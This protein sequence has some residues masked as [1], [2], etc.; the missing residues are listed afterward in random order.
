MKTK[1][2]VESEIASVN[3]EMNHLARRKYQSQSDH[4]EDS[5]KIEHLSGRLRTLRWFI[6]GSGEMDHV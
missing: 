4:D 1:A 5:R 6:F 2:E 3:R